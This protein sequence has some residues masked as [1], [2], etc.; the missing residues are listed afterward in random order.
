MKI[1]TGRSSLD[2]AV[3]EPDS[4]GM[5]VNSYTPNDAVQMTHSDQE[6]TPEVLRPLL[7]FGNRLNNAQ[8]RGF[9]E[10]A[11]LEQMNI[12][13]EPAAE[14]GPCKCT[15]VP[16]LA[17]P[18]TLPK[19]KEF[20]LPMIHFKRP[21]FQSKFGT[22]RSRQAKANSIKQQDILHLSGERSPFRIQKL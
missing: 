7:M 21:K 5:Y 3:N 12:Q 16:A 9:N 15:P 1:R 20:S 10:A 8:K 17:L 13:E 4:M 2:H 14:G 11:P 19:P 6:D 18:M 22:K